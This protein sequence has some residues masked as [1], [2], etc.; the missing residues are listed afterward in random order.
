MKFQE[1]IESADTLAEAET[2]NRHH[3]LASLK[4]LARLT[5]L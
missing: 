5:L 4:D 2:S 3:N 1:F